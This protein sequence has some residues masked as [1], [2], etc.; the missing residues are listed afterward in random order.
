MIL[1]KILNKIGVE[2]EMD[3]Q[4]KE[5]STTDI[6]FSQIIDGKSVQI[7]SDKKTQRRGRAKKGI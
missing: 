4:Y 2:Y 5:E 3:R 7:Y 6:E 1:K